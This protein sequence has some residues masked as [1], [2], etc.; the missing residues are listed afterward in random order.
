VE[1]R[2]AAV[3]IGSNTVHVLVADVGEDGRLVDVAHYVEMPELGARV[4][5]DG[6]VGREGVADALAALGSV[7]DRA[8]GHGYERLLA[9]ATAAVRRASDGASLL[10]A[11]AERARVPVRLLSEAREARLSF[12]GVASRHAAPGD[13][14]MADLG[15]GSTELV[16]ARG[17]DMGA[18]ASLALG[19]G[20]LAARYLSDPPRDGERAVLRR[21]ARP[22][23]EGA[24]DVHAQRLVVTGGTAA[25]LPLLLG[26]PERP[27]LA[28]RELHDARGVLDERPAAAI[29]A[30]MGIPEKRVRA[31]R[32]GVEV[33]ASLLQ[34]YHL[35]GFDISYEGLRHGMLTAY[36]REGENWWRG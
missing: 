15:G 11:A 16:A 28:A 6:R 27:A 17:E 22:A 36:L 30:A 8:A 12:L 20:A 25:T 18:W 14:L 13:W 23:L 33:L 29:E 35:G 24:P 7:L 3:D 34:R 2:L 4:D 31:L 10:E 32:G 5:R 19:S 9:G 1:G 21:A 26:H